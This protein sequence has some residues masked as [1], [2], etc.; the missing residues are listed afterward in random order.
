MNIVVNMLLP[1]CGGTV[2]YDKPLY[3]SYSLVAPN[4][5]D[6]GYILKCE[7]DPYFESL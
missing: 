3:L 1:L 4:I 7:Y 6:M 2:V 5:P